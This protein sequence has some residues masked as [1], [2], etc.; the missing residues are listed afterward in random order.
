LQVLG[1]QSAV[2]NVDVAFQKIERK[3]ESLVKA[4][5]GTLVMNGAEEP[6]LRRSWCQNLPQISRTVTTSLNLPMR[7]GQSEGEYIPAATDKAA[8]S[9][10]AMLSE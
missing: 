4:K 2:G 1:E 9:E 3:V 5:S 6:T 8:G 10:Y 7:G